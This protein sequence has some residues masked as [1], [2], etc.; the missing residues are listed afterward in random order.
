MPTYDKKALSQAV[1]DALD[2]FAAGS[3][4]RSID[5]TWSED[6][7]TVNVG[8]VVSQEEGGEVNATAAADNEDEDVVYVVC[9]QDGPAFVRAVE[10]YLVDDTIDMLDRAAAA[11]VPETCPSCYRNPCIAEQQRKAF[12]EVGDKMKAMGRGIP[13]H[14]QMRFHCYRYMTYVIH[15]HL[16]EGDRRKLPSCVE[17][18]IHET[19][20][21]KE[22]VGFKPGTKTTGEENADGK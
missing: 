18:A 1:G 4:L 22:F 11:A 17:A 12:V 9:D 3:G 21:D 6:G 5:V 2:A 19:Y 15:G 13:T 16:G 14:K 20:P 8:P 7:N 10:E